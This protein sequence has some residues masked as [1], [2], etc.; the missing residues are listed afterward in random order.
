[1]TEFMAA[2]FCGRLG[3]CRAKEYVGRD[4]WRTELEF[5]ESP[6]N[7]SDRIHFDVI[8]KTRFVMK[9]TTEF[10][11]QRVRQ[12]IGKSR[13]QYARFPIVPCQM[14][15]P[16]QRHDRLARARGAGHPRRTVE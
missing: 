6:T 11:P 2:D 16:V 3:Q 14:H 12:S 10:S 4:V 15:S 9:Q 7:R 1:M 13:E 5:K 8:A